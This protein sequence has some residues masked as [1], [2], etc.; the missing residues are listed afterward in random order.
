MKKTYLNPK[1]EIIII[2]TSSMLCLS[3]GMGGQQSN[4]DALGREDDDYEW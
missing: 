1:M 4:S 2:E 3:G